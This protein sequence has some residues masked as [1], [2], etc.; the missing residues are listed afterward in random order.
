MCCVVIETA[1]RK[2]AR[3]CPARKLMPRLRVA[4]VCRGLV[5]GLT[6]VARSQVEDHQRY[7]IRSRFVSCPFM[8]R[9]L[10]NAAQILLKG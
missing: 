5:E 3:T 9:A 7:E 4:G 8:R 10:I 2:I 6:A 1:V